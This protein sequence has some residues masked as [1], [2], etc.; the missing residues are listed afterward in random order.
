MA[1]TTETTRKFY[2]LRKDGK[3]LRFCADTICDVNEKGTSF[4]FKRDGEVVGE[5]QCQLHAWWA[6]D[7][8]AGKTWTL[9]VAEHTISV[10]ADERICEGDANFP[11]TFRREGEVVAVVFTRYHTWSVEG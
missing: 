8:A 5:A 1:P 6:D 11:N 2:L 7:G 3:T 4:R 10:V 9:E